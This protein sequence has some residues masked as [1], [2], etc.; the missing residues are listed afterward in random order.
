MSTTDTS[1]V[2]IEIVYGWIRMD[3]IEKAEPD[4]SLLIGH[5]FTDYDGNGNVRSVKEVY[6]GRLFYE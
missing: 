1:E 3:R 5:R 2:M 4:G 6:S